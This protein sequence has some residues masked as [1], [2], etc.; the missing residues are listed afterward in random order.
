M[1]A[2]A[3]LAVAGAALLLSTGA[4]ATTTYYDYADA[5]STSQGSFALTDTGGAY[6]LSSFAGTINSVRYTTDTVALV[7]VNDQVRF[8]G[9]LNGINAALLGTDD[10]QTISLLDPQLMS[11]RLLVVF[12]TSAFAN[13][14]DGVFGTTFINVT[15]VAAPALGAVP[16]PATWVMMI[17]GFG[18][19]GYGMRRRNDGSITQVG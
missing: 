18:A 4:D 10:F 12:T 9:S 6:S 15:R 8:G 11:S 19:V 5:T 2:I 17:V 1:K 14:P 16:E 13:N 3:K 7:Q